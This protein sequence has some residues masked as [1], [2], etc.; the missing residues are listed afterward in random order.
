M[1]NFYK[2]FQKLK[3]PTT[4]QYSAFRINNFKN[5][6]I[7]KD[8]NSNPSLLIFISNNNTNTIKQELYNL[9]ISHNIKCNIVENEVNIEG[10]FSIISYS[11]HDN[12][13]IEYFLKMC[14]IF[15]FTLGNIPTDKQ[16]NQV[17]N[18]FIEL[19][20]LFT[21]PPKKTIQGLWAE[22]F[23]ISQANDTK[24]AVLAWHDGITDKYDFSF[25][26]I[27]LDVKSTSSY[28]RIHNF[29]MEQLQA[30]KDTQM[31]VASIFVKII[32]NGISIQDLLNKIERKLNADIKIINKLR[33]LTFSTLSN[34]VRL[35]DAY[36]FD[37]ELAKE[38]LKI[39][40]S[41]E[42]PKINKLSISKGVFDVLFKS[43]LDGIKTIKVIF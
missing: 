41:N 8:K 27:R 43:N 3:L 19:F 36:Y 6:R 26:G 24:K 7:A 11:G 31:Y 35:V 38:S 37:Y 22:L 29:S 32:S 30:P 5:H 15:I 39:Y 42:I 16:V 28:Q 25:K 14:E 40:D 20:R 33:F 17:I 18:K 21:E 10:V 13:L 2:K 23:F 4:S 1:Y 34:N 9:T 12:E